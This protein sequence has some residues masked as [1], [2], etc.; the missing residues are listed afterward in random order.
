MDNLRQSEV[1]FKKNKD[2]VNKTR[3]SESTEEDSEKQNISNSLPTTKG[4]LSYPNINKVNNRI[5]V[6]SPTI[7]QGLDRECEKND[8]MRIGDKM[9]ELGIYKGMWLVSHKRTEILY[10][11]KILHKGKI[12]NMNLLVCHHYYQ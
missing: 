12:I 2:K 8:F 4:K 1:N 3:I 10:A 7:S 5:F 11:I 6:L 9:I